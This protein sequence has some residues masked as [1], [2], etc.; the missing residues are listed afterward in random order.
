MECFNWNRKLS[1]K[2]THQSSRLILQIN[3]TDIRITSLPDSP[4]S[5][6]GLKSFLVFY[7]QNNVRFT[8]I[9]YEPLVI[10]T[11]YQK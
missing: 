9:V 3:K 4:A 6:K 10:I 7:Y 1:I 2:Y 5:L 11:E 8:L